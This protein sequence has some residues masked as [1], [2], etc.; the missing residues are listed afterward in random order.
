MK[1]M[2]MAET[3]T[4]TEE[5]VTTERRLTIRVAHANPAPVET[6]EAAE[7]A[8]VA[9]ASEKGLFANTPGVRL[10]DETDTGTGVTLH[11]YEFTTRAAG[12]AA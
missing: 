12:G 7:S 1:G 4:T 11:V 2:N 5:A 3:P 8:A 10:A 9:A 6:A